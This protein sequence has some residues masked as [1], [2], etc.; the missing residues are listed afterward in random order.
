MRVGGDEW[1]AKFAAGSFSDLYILC[2]VCGIKI[3]TYACTS[4]KPG[5]G[6]GSYLD[7]GEVELLPKGKS[8]PIVEIDLLA[9]A[10]N[11]IIS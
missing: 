9:V 1:S 11:K 3:A 7:I 8:R 10:D 2:E 6:A 4:A 5:T